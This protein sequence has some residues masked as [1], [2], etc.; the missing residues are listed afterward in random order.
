MIVPVLSNPT[1]L[2][3]YRSSIGISINK[4]QLPLSVAINISFPPSEVSFS[5]KRTL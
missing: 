3:V 2:V 1:I 5:A 4:F